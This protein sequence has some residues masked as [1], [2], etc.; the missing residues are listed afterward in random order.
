MATAKKSTTKSK[1]KP[2]PA[3]K[4]KPAAKPA[5]KAAAKAAAPV[6][7]K[8]SPQPTPPKDSMLSA[9]DRKSAQ[10]LPS[11]LGKALSGKQPAMSPMDSRPRYDNNVGMYEAGGAWFRVVL[12]AT[13]DGTPYA[14]VQ[15]SNNKIRVGWVGRV[16]LSQAMPLEVVKFESDRYVPGQLEELSKLASHAPA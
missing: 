3:A 13:A 10:S 15:P 7:A 2:A 4:K 16:W 5:A 12:P 6:K 11:A 8:A 9:G 1:S 14:L